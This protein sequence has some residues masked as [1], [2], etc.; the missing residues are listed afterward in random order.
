MATLYGSAASAGPIGQSTQSFAH[1]RTRTT[2][3]TYDGTPATTDELVIGYFKSTDRIVDIELATDGAATAGALNI[4]LHTASFS[5][6]S[7]ELTVSDADR[8]ASA[9]SVASAIA[10]DARVSVFDESGT[11]DDVM[12]RGKTIW[13]LAGLSEDDGNTYAITATPS[14]TVDA[15]TEMIFVV[16]Y[17]AGD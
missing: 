15:A 14:T 16:T 6:D 13:E 10:F 3:S 17:V 11:L 4:G 1:A 2:L 5:N 7:T 8:F 12:D 9:Q